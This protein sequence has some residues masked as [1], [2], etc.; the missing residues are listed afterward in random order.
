MTDSPRARLDP[1]YSGGG[2]FFRANAPEATVTLGHDCGRRQMRA[3]SD[4]N[5]TDGPGRAGAVKRP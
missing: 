1:L 2:S 3:C 4:G 5:G